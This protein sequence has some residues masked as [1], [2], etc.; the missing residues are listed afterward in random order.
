MENRRDGQVKDSTTCLLSASHIAVKNPDDPVPEWEPD[1]II[2]KTP[3]RDIINEV[4]LR[5]RKDRGSGEYSGLAMA[6]G[7][8]EETG[9][10][11]ISASTN[12]ATLTS[13]P[14]TNL[15]LNDVIYP[16]GGKDYKVTEVVS[17][18]VYG[19]TPVDSGAVVVDMPSAV[20]YYAGANLSGDFKRSQLRYKTTNPLGEETKDFRKLG[21]FTSDL[22]GDSDTADKFIEHL[23]EWRAERR[24]TVEFATF[25]NAI[26]VELGDACFFDHPWLPASKRPPQRGVVRRRKCDRHDLPYELAVVASKRLLPR[27][28]QGGRQGDFGVG[29]NPDRSQRTMQH[30]SGGAR[31]RGD[32]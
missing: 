32:P 24:L 6:T 13:A 11:T 20:T 8:H 15:S 17:S 28:R 23:R 21:G 31:E 12:R 26:D 19:I 27:C 30:D 10:C 7:R 4:I 18:T 5:Y 1:L 16:V 25:L 3:V 22:I 14:S 2:G 9:T 29:V